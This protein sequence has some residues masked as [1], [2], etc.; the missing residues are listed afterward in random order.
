VTEVLPGVSREAAGKLVGVVRRDP[1]ITH[2][3]HL[4][5]RGLPD[6]RRPG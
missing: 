4:R 2:P 1:V 3:P 6:R 5:A